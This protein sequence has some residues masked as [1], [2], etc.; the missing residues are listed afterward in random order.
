[1]L[2]SRVADRI[3]W[4]ARYI[5]RSEDTARLV[6]AHGELMADL[7]AHVTTQWEPLVTVVGSDAQYERTLDVDP[8]RVGARAHSQPQAAQAG[9]RAPS[10]QGWRRKWRWP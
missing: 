2:L 3:Y 7:P 6:R 4:A 1:M 8:V 5:E 9:S 10:P